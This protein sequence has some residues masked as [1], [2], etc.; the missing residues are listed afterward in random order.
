VTAEEL[1]AILEYFGVLGIGG[2]IGGGLMWVI[3]KSYLPAYISEK[4]RNLATKEDISYITTQVESIKAKYSE[5]LQNLA[6]Q[7]TLLVEGFKNSLSKEQEFE[8]TANAAVVD[9]TKKLAAGSQ[10]I[11]WLSWSATEPKPSLLD[12]DFADYDKGMIVVLSELVGLQASVAALDPSR[13]PKLSDFAEELYAREVEVGKARDLFRTEGPEKDVKQAQAIARLKVIY[14]Q[15]IDFDKRLLAA[16]T[17]L[18]KPQKVG[19]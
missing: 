18:L 17:G 7:Q 4:G 5:H 19:E 8:R 14:E 2:M 12:S 16:V 10:L 13:F 3:V 1:K 6:Q 11:S 9:L 15:S